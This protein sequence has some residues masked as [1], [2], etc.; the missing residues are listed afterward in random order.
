MQSYE[1]ITPQMCW[2]TIQ[3]K[4]PI[5]LPSMGH[6][7]QWEQD[8]A[9]SQ[10][11]CMSNKLL[12]TNIIH[13]FGSIYI[14]IHLMYMSSFLFSCIYF[15]YSMGFARERMGESEYTFCLLIH[16]L[17]PDPAFF[18]PP[19]LPGHAGN[20]GSGLY[21]LPHASLSTV[22]WWWCCYFNGTSLLLLLF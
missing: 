4:D 5:L 22:W 19:R 18:V 2:D 7:L 1:F 15:Y 13:C 3:Y 6:C 11:N 14:L 8:W 16:K 9:Q 10:H 20:A 21:I 12:K 17:E